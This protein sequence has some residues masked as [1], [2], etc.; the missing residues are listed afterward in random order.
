[1]RMRTLF[2][3]LAA[4]IFVCSAHAEGLTP[5]GAAN[6]Q[7]SAPE[8]DERTLVESK[9]FD[10]F[11]IGV[12]GGLSFMPFYTDIHKHLNPNASLRI[13]R[14]FT[15]VFGLALD[16]SAYLDDKPWNTIGS[17]VKYTNAGAMATINLSNW[18][19]GYGERPRPFEVEALFGFGWGHAFGQ[20]GQKHAR[21]NDLTSRTGLSLAWNPGWNRAWKIFLE[22]AMAWNILDGSARNEGVQYNYKK[23]FAQLNLGVCYRFRNSHGSHNFKRGGMGSSER[24]LLQGK[25]REL[26]LELDSTIQVLGDAQYTLDRQEKTIG[27]LQFES[28]STTQEIEAIRKQV[29][30]LPVMIVFRQGSSEVDE[31]QLPNLELIANYMRQHPKAVVQVRG[32]ATPDADLADFRRMAEARAGSVKYLLAKRF[33]IPAERL[34]AVGGGVTNELFDQTEF[35]RIVTFKVL[36]EQ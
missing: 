2:S 24:Y 30:I 20:P 4:S 17:V 26:A 6:R 10:N 12:G 1:M 25:V 3:L 27:R 29:S 23:C 28:D 35:N 13:G 21:Q 11:Y 31:A 14:Y 22:P 16:A 5:V 34:L 18:I 19:G 33:N 32:Y 15:P 7:Q 36:S 9:T 8:T